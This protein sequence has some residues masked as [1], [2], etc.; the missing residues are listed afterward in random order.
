MSET[1]PSELTRPPPKAVAESKTELSELM[2]PNH[3]NFSGNVHGGI[4]LMLLDRA[5]YITACKHS[6]HY[7]VTASV[8]RVDFHDAIKVGSVLH[9]FASV[10]YVGRSSMEIGIRVQTEDFHRGEFKHTNTCFFTMV[11]VD[12]DGRPVPVPE[13]KLETEED[14]RRFEAGHERALRRKEDRRARLKQH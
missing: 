13:L 4:L 10:N 5:A 14:R 8:D 12:E 1:R 9:L 6:N 3:A 11:A 7:C 2:I